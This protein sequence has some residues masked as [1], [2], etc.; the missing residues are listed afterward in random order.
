MKYLFPFFLCLLSLNSC[1]DSKQVQSTELPSKPR[2]SENDPNSCNIE[3]TVIKILPIDQS[4]TDISPDHPCKAE[5][6][7]TQR[8]NCGVDISLDQNQVVTVKFSNT[9]DAT[10]KIKETNNR[11]LPGL[12]EGDLFKAKIFSRLTMG[13]GKTYTIHNYTKL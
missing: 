6:K 3:A 2:I 1:K 12:K 7:I 8:E 13:S 9:L 5:I 10:K 4:C 11:N